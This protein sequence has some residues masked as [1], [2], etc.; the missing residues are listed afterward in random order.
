MDTGSSPMTLRISSRRSWSRIRPLNRVPVDEDRLRRRR[1]RSLPDSPGISLS[2]QRLG[3]DGRDPLRLRWQPGH[4]GTR[5]KQHAHRDLH[6]GIGHERDARRRW[7]H[8]RIAARTDN[9]LL[10]GQTGDPHA[11]YHADGNG[12]VTMLINSRQIPVAKVPLRPIR[13]HHRQARTPGRRQYLSLLQQRIPRQERP[14]L[15]RKTVLRRKPSTM[16]N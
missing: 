9:S 11:Y 12:N 5:W 3:F 15:L 8:W 2:E 4:S 6:P 10:I 1:K 13:K 16:A 7:W 14:L